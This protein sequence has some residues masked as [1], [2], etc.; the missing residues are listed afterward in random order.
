ML[1]FKNLFLNYLSLAY[2]LLSFYFC[3]MDIKKEPIEV[4]SFNM[5]LI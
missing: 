3:L 5:S 2:S 1:K 4:F